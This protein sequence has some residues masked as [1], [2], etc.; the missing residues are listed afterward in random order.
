MR[1]NAYLQNICLLAAASSLVLLVGCAKQEV[2]LS[3]S[4][5]A[6]SERS[7]TSNNQTVVYPDGCPSVPDGKAAYDKMNCATCH[8]VSGEAVPGKSSIA[9]SDKEY[10]HQQKP[11]AQFEFLS[12]GKPGSEHPALNDKLTRREIWNLVFYTRSLAMPLLSSKEWSEV[13]V[14]FGSNCA[15]CHGKIGYGDGPLAHNLEPQPANFQNFVRFYD[16][17]D[18]ILWDHIANGIKW[19]GMPNF[20]GKEDK[21]KNV[22]FDRE[23]IWKLVQY[24]RNFQETN[25]STIAQ[26]TNSANPLSKKGSN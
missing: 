2:T 10:L 25:Q 19:E 21:A 3:G 26:E 15:V 24:V 7:V 18:D 16:R 14:V 4:R 17:T 8:G 13:D 22:K 11:V 5:D 9:L 1:F 23:Y 20:L 6:L 12:F